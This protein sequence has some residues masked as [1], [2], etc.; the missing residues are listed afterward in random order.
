M[1]RSRILGTGHYVPPRV[2]TNHDLEAALD[3]SHDWIVQRTGIHERRFVDPGVGPSDLGV[4]ASKKALEAAGL[5]VDDIDLIIFATLSPDYTFPGSGVLVQEKMGFTRTVPAL[6]IR[7]QCTGFLYSLSVAD[8]FVKTGTYDHVLIIGSEVHS[9]GLDMMPRGRDVSVIFG[10][11]AG[12]VVVGPSEADDRG[13]MSVHLHSEGKHAKRLWLELPGS[14]YHDR[15]GDDEWWE[16]AGRQWP[17]MEGRYVFTNAL[18]R[19][20]EVINEALSANGKS[21]DEI[22]ILVPHQANLRIN[23]KV[24]EIMN[25]PPEKVINNI[26]KYGNTTAGSI[27]IALDEAVRDGRIKEGDLVMLAGFGAGFTWGSALLRW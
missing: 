25:L 7:N 14:I 27:P 15:F 23:D 22:D 20:P 16:E 4:E 1:R 24:A 26:Q 11:G 18:T 21:L 19:L 12:A 5:N 10:D 8:Q 2:V 3:T 9:T 13:V 17:K 6:D